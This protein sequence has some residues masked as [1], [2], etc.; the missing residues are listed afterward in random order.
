MVRKEKVNR[1]IDGDTF[2]TNSRKRPIRLNRVDT[3]EKKEAGFI[4]AKQALNK[5]IGK[6]EVTID[7][8][9]RDVY[10]RA[11]A[12]VKVDG[13]SVNKAMKKFEK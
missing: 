13:K 5:L 11:V 4:K 1:I 2:M 7:T 12:N 3:P 9:A 10:N 8:V 6:K